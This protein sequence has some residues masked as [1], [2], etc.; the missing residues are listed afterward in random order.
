MTS[1]LR[2]L[3]TALKHHH[4]YLHNLN[5][6]PTPIYVIGNPSADLDSIISAII[7]AYHA[8]TNTPHI[9][10]INLPNVPSGSEL[11]RLRPEF[12]KALWL[13]TH[14]PAVP[15]PEEEWDERD[16]AAFLREHCLTV[17]DFRSHLA[18]STTTTTTTSS[19]STSTKKDE[20]CITANAVLVDWNALPNLKS[21]S[22]DG[23]EGVRFH[24]LGC[25]DHHVDEGVLAPDS[26]PRI[27]EKSGSCASL[28]ILALQDKGL[29]N[30]QAKHHANHDDKDSNHEHEHKD[31]DKDGDT[32][33]IQTQ[34]STLASVP[35][36]IDTANLTSTD[37]TTPHDTSAID[38]LAPHLR[39][40]RSDL[41]AT[42]QK[43]KEES[44]DL[45]TLPEMLDRD[46]K[47]WSE[48]G[49]TTKI[50]IGFCSMVRP[51]SWLVEKVGSPREFL[52]G[53]CDFSV[54]RAL[55]VV[56]VMTAFSEGGR[57][58]RELFVVARGDVARQAVGAFVECNSEGLGLKGWEGRGCEAL[59]GDEGVWR[60]VWVQEDLS[61][62]RKQVAPLMRE[63]VTSL[64]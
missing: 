64:K 43:T 58:C 1:L 17:S 12:T 54:E 37:K 41:Y 31:K 2:F 59:N 40:P 49:K 34:L 13:S 63:A 4:N 50:E 57:F 8:S 48:V 44:L 16:P 6:N 22:L 53:V 5:P 42:V 7:Y 25:I 23:L 33:S 61:K 3:R 60:R 47:Q 62:S 15:V 14:H 46:Y 36:L 52:N 51:V 24:V 10:L 55:D 21:G 56:V 19:S 26:H 32:E 11:R 35:I 38:R 39:I 27:I 9:P 18:S 20:R 30:Q 45:L 28:V 29:W